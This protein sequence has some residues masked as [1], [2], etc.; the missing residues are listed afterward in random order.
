MFT[1]EH[2]GMHLGDREGSDGAV[3]SPRGRDLHARSYAQIE[4]FPIIAAIKI[5]HKEFYV[6]RQVFILKNR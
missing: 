4:S 3:A 2:R 5:L 6:A 1:N